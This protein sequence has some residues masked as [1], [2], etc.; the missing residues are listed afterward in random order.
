MRYERTK[1]EVGAILRIPVSLVLGLSTVVCRPKI[2]TNI[3]YHR[4]FLH[5]TL[6]H[7]CRQLEM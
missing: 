3:L 1:T 6:D 7:V 5:V 2:T 4:N